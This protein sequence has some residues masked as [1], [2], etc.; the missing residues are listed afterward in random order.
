[1]CQIRRGASAV[2]VTGRDL[3]KGARA[4]ERIKRESGN[5][6]V[7][8]KKLDLSSQKDVRR[9]AAEVLEEHKKI[10]FLVWWNQVSYIK[11]SYWKCKEKGSILVNKF[12]S[13]SSSNKQ[14]TTTAAGV[15]T[16]TTNFRSSKTI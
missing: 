7:T 4:V 14:T 1:M 9:L 12:N 5:K 6:N 3:A 8:L 16:S 2:V 10:H 15:S 11:N 13:S